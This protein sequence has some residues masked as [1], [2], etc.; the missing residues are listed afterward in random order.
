[1][2]QSDVRWNL[3]LGHAGQVGQKVVT[4]TSSGQTRQVEASSLGR[5]PVARQCEWRMLYDAAARM[6]VDLVDR[7]IVEYGEEI[8]DAHNH[9]TG[10]TDVFSSRDHAGMIDI[11]E[12]I[13]GIPIVLHDEA[14]FALC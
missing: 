9:R 13:G 5:S 8:T 10:E 11:I 14:M 3:L 6:T 2:T 7:D 12:M 4:L 1:E